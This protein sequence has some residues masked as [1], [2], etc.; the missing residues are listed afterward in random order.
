MS[1]LLRLARCRL[2]LPRPLLALLGHGL[3]LVAERLHAPD[4]D[5]HLP[6]DVPRSDDLVADRTKW[7]EERIERFEEHGGVKPPQAG[8]SRPDGRRY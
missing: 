3:A 7:G 5:L 6:F 8:P 2:A 4:I 1:L